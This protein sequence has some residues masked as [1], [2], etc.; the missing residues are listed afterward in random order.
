MKRVFV[1]DMLSK[2]KRRIRLMMLVLIWP[3]MFVQGQVGETS[4]LVMNDDGSV[5][6]RYEDAKAMSMKVICDCELHRKTAT[7]RKENYHSVKMTRDSSGCWTYTTP[8]LAP[9]VYTYQFERN[10]VARF[11]DPENP[12]SIRVHS[13]KMSVFIIT[14]TPQVDLYVEETLHGRLDTLVFQSANEDKPRRLLV[15]TPPQYSEGQDEFPVLYLLHGLN[16]NEL[17]WNERGRA[18]Q[19]LDNLIVQHKVKPM[20]LVMPDANPLCLIP[21]KE[22]AS[23]AKNLFLYPAW[24]R[25]EFE[26]CFPEMDTFLTERYRMT[27]Y[28]G[29]RAVAGLS[30]GAKQAANLANMYCGTFVSVGMFSPVVGHRQVPDSCYTKYWIGGG[31]G[32]P[33]HRRINKFR[34]RIQRSHI[35]YTMY[36]S[37]GGHTWRNW[38]V[39]FTDYVQTLFWNL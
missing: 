16:G 11:P 29:G 30:A 17:A 38:R 1:I 13:A 27:A 35:Y 6:F 7:V 24:G 14:G 25:R 37:R 31:T 32:D 5:T 22:K 2:N 26:K 21:Q 28:P 20:I 12:D 4:H 33:F 39:Y 10:G 19:I 15:Y 8:P 18:T 34:K 23:L 3:F 36:N 9:E